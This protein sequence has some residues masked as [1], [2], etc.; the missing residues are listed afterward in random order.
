M[1]TIATKPQRAQA[2]QNY[3]AVDEL[4]K[5]HIVI[6]EDEQIVIDTL[7]LV[8]QPHFNLIFFTRANAALSY[9]QQNWQAIDLIILDYM[10]PDMNGL[11]LLSII[12][13]DVY[14]KRLPIILYTACS[15]EI[16]NKTTIKPD[17]YLEKSCTRKQMLTAICDVIGCPVSSVN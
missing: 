5:S 1:M 16:L 7:Q 3:I 11:E 2:N 8:L 13:Q 12:K 9:I 17:L 4:D 10:L 6:V 14:T 15:K